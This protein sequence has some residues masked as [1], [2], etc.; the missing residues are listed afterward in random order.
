MSS[1][2]ASNPVFSS[3]AVDRLAANDSSRV[4]TRFGSV[5]KTVFLT[6]LVMLSGAI[7]WK[8][9]PE[10]PSAGTWFA[11]SGVSFAAFILAM[12][13]IFKGA[14]NIVTVGAYA[15]ME[16]VILGVVSGAYAT[17]YDGI[18]VQAV[19]LTFAIL[20]AMLLLYSLKLVRVTEKTRSVILIMTFGVM[21]Y[22]FME[23]I[24]GLFFPFIIGNIQ[25]GPWGVFISALIVFAAA[26][27]LLL[28]FDFIDHGVAAKLPKKAEW[29][30]AFGLMLTLIWLYVSILRLLAAARR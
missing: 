5:I 19:L 1:S 28:D 27:N 25:I 16:G 10:V 22:V 24:L 7:A 3:N 29:Y 2:M 20:I 17:F 8:L 4:M 23:F 15:L 26:L 11:L 13:I 14:A 30:A 12:V 21:V 9:M 6:I 18:V